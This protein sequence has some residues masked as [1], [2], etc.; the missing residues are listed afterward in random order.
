MSDYDE[1]E[2]WEENE[3]EDEGIRENEEEVDIFGNMEIN[4]VER[5]ALSHPLLA[6]QLDDLNR[7]YETKER[8]AIQLQSFYLEYNEEGLNISLNNILD[9]VQDERITNIKH[10]NVKC[11]ALGYYVIS[12]FKVDGDKLNDRVVKFILGK[13]EEVSKEDIIRYARYLIKV[14]S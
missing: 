13:N 14:M 5:V 3:W 12:N 7:K 10:R 1:N 8:F 11:M 6:N 9:M 2:D 4:A